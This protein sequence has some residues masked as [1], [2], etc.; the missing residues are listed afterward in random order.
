MHVTGQKS[1]KIIENSTSCEI[2]LPWH[3]A[4]RAFRLLLEHLKMRDFPVKI[5]LGVILVGKK[6]G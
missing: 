4:Q 3:H 5:Q 6:N 2:K 1:A